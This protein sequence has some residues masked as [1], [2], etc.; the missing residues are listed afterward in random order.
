MAAISGSNSISNASNFEVLSKDL[1]IY[2]IA[3]ATGIHKSTR[4]CFPKTLR[5]IIVRSK[6]G[7]G[8]YTTANDLTV[9]LEG[10]YAGAGATAAAVSKAVHTGA[11]RGA[12]TVTVAAVT[13]TG[14]AMR[15]GN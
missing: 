9:V 14:D 10:A 15:K 13:I 7:N 12:S 2:T 3:G 11:S 8:R 1:E 5:A 4:I 6:R